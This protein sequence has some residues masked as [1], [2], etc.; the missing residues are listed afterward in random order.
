MVIAMEELNTLEQRVE[1]I[2]ERHPG[3]RSDYRLLV[4]YSWFYQ[5]GNRAFLRFSPRQLSLMASPESITRAYRFIVSRRP[6]LAAIPEVQELREQREEAMRLH[7]ER[8]GQ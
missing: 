8:D 5:S 6:E 7:Y 1:K 3:A 4:L 2:L